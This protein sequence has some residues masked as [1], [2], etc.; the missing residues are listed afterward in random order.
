MAPEPPTEIPVEAIEQSARACLE[1]LPADSLERLAR[2]V[3][4]YAIRQRRLAERDEAVR[5]LA[6][7]HYGA[8]PSGRAIAAEIRRA[9]SIYASGPA[10]RRDEPPSDARRASLH[11]VLELSGGRVPSVGTLRAAL[12]GIGPSTGQNSPEVFSHEMGDASPNV[13]AVR[14]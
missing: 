10:S 9:L 8:L 1:W 7:E 3:A 2:Y 13:V 14:R 5:R 4:P 11:H 12:A 6:V